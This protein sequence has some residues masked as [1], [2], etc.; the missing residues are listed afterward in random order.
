MMNKPVLLLLLG[1]NII[2]PALAQDTLKTTP[3]QLKQVTVTGKSDLRAAKEQAYTVT[4]IDATRLHNTTRDINQVLNHSTGVKIRE[5][6]GLG[7]NYSFSLNGFTGKQVKFFLDGMPMDNFGSSLSLNN[8]PINMAERIEIYK[9]VVPVFLGSDALGGAVNVVT[10]QKI[11]K[12]L[13]ASYSIGSFNT[14]RASINSRYTTDKG[15]TI[16]LNGF[17]NYS[18]N[19][20]KIDVQIP[21]PQTGIYGNTLRIKRFH[22]AYHSAMGQVE[23][24]FVNKQ[25]AD[26][27]LFGLI[28]S[29]NRKEVQTGM[30]M[31]LVSGQVFNSSNSI[32]PTFKYKKEN[33]FVPGLTL[34]ANANMSFVKSG[35][36]D[37]SS[38]L[39][40]WY[41]N[42]TVKT[43]GSNSGELS[44]YKTKFRF[45]DRN[46]LASA[47]LSYE[48]NKNHNFSLNHNYT[49][50]R[51]KGDDPIAIDPIP[52]DIPNTLSKNITGLAYKYST[53]SNR[54]SA[55]VFAKQFSMSAS[56]VDAEWGTHESMKTSYNRTGYGVA[57]MYYVFPFAQVKASYESTWRLPEGEEMFGNGLLLKNNPYL[58]PEHSHN[59]NVGLALMKTFNKHKLEG[60]I[61]YLYRKAGD[62][63]R[64]E[65]D[66]QISR[67]SN[68]D[69]V[70]TSGVEWSVRYT[71]DDALTVEVNSTYQNTL[72]SKT[73]DHGI[74]NYT[75]W[76]RLPNMPYLFGSFDAGYKL[77]KAFYSHDALTFGVG[78]NFV[79]K[80][81]LFWP[82]QGSAGT[83]FIIPRQFT[84]D[85]AVTY[86]LQNGKYNMAVE[87][88]NL[89]NAKLYDNFKL[90]KPGRAFNVKL[91]YF[92]HN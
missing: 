47:N 78:G 24:G 21:D 13:D 22:D 80:F 71:Y 61:N 34:T 87:C 56:T 35:I 25:F 18:D 55:T 84:Q 77:K 12:Y 57:A 30:N 9:G 82:S 41:G 15:F 8:L 63:I 42:Y 70:R 20:Y 48:L 81:Y 29:E 65:S 19:N 72:N 14:H 89:S 11:K 53:L 86:S 60:E 67:Y 17:Y 75:Y 37:T 49:Y 40:D 23:A 76:D 91:R 32:I 38:R 74:P 28:V 52:F 68:L 92:F 33:F 59:I 26:K 50:A 3:K 43:F 51:R 66:G 85:A 79:E 31:D 88:T 27:L 58:K 36:T 90:Q 4:A 62:F 83:K 44:Y 69:S 39:Y 10:N 64:L 16:N 6:G 73:F 7:S 54:F 45:N 2:V 5:E 46:A 1:S